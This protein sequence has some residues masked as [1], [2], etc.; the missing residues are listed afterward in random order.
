MKKHDEGYV[1]ILVL[2]VM[3][4]MGLV[5][6]SILTFSLRNL[7]NQQLSIERMADK[8]AAQGMIEEYFEKSKQNG[9]ITI[10]ESTIEGEENEEEYLKA[11]P[12]ENSKS[13]EAGDFVEAVIVAKYHSVTIDCKVRVYGTVSEGKPYFITDPEI[14]YTSYKITYSNGETEEEVPAT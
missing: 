3:I 12:A 2:V 6:A 7:Q 4:V 11:T 8:Y 13:D 10:K 14:T 5:T 9:G 1:M